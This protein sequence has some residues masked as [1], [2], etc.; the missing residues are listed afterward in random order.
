TCKLD[1]ARPFSSS[2]AAFPHLLRRKILLVPFARL[3]GA[4]EPR[5]PDERGLHPVVRL[6]EAP[7]DRATA[8]VPRM[9]AQPV[10]RAALC[11]L[12]SYLH[13]EGLGHAVRRHFL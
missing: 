4:A 1:L 12:L 7:A 9:G 6:G 5:V 3:R 11:D 2:A 10:R 13:R 8:H